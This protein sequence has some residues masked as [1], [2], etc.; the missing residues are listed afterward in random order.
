MRLQVA[1]LAE[2][3]GSGTDTVHGAIADQLASQARRL[4]D[5][6]T[7]I[8]RLAD[9]LRRDLQRV[10]DGRDADEPSINGILHNTAPTLDLL[11]A[12]RTELHRSL[13]DLVEV[14]KGLPPFT[15][16]PVTA[17]ATTARQRAASTRAPRRGPT[18]T[19][20]TTST[21]ANTARARA[22]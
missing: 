11:A 21:P 20:S 3:P 22:R 7:R 5:V 2:L 1:R 8:V 12:R 10:V 9:A 16:A 6:Q 15:P 4:D 18:E 17:E 14:Y 19:S 13:T